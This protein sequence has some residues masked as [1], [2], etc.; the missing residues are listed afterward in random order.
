MP[1][2]SMFFGIKVMINYN[3]HLPPH[4]HIEYSGEKAL[5]SIYDS[6]V[7]RGKLPKRQLRMVLAW[8]EIHRDELM[9]N[10]E[11]AKENIPLRK[12]DPL[13]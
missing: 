7:I 5:V 6:K 12:I 2:I 11:L 9:Q 4:F 3:G 10:W 8:A 1:I 13:S